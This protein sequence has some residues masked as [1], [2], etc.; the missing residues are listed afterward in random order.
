MK[1]KVSGIYSITSRKNGKRYIGSSIGIDRRWRDHLHDLKNNKHFNSHL[2]N[3]YNKYGEDDLIFTIVEVINR[4]KLSLQDF[5]KLL[6]KCEQ[7]YLND[8]ECCHFNSYKFSNSSLFCRHSKAKNYTFDKSRNKYRVTYSVLGENLN[9]G[10]F[11]TES[12]AIDRVT[13]LKTLT[14]QELIELQIFDKN[15]KTFY[16]KT[17]RPVKGYTYSK[18]IKKWRVNLKIDGKV[19]YFGSFKIEQEAIDKVK[20]ILS[21]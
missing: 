4:D 7:K 6:L 9:F 5:K 15:N 17:N 14:D 21:S 8:W 11:A 3:H 20:E 12:E 13:F 16:T 2:Q 10:T 18:E 1:T 19:K